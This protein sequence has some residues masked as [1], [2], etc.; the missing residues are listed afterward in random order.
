MANLTAILLKLSMLCSG[1][2][3]EILTLFIA[4]SATA[5]TELERFRTVCHMISVK[6]FALL[7]PSPRPFQAV[8]ARVHL[9]PAKGAPRAGAGAAQENG[10]P[11]RA[12][13]GSR[14]GSRAWIR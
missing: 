12:R 9:R 7:A 10:P 6:I 5:V 3:S 14:T 8:T 2:T 4:N 11:M 1:E 13:A